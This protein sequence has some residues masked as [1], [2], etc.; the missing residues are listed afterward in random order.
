MVFDV[1]CFDVSLM[2]V[3]VRFEEVVLM[4]RAVLPCF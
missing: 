4:C 3:L 1:L 2:V